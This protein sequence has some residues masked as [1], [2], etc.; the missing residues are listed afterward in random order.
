MVTLMTIVILSISLL[1]YLKLVSNQ[2]ASVARA[3][4][5][6][7][8]IPVAEAG[9]EEALTQ[10]HYNG[11][12][13]LTPNG[14]SYGADKLFHKT[15]LF[16]NDGS[17]YSVSIQPTNPPIIVSTGYVVLSWTATASNYV[18]RKVRVNTFKPR[19]HGGGLN[20]KNS[21]SLSG[22]SYVDSFDSSDP[23]YS[24]GG[25]YDVTKRKDNGKVLTDSGA[26]GAIDVGSAKIYGSAVTGPTGTV[27]VGSG[28]IGDIAWDASHSGAQPG[29][30]ANDANVQF[31]DVDAPFPFATGLP[32]VGGTNAGVY[33]DY[34]LGSGNY[35][36][37][38]VS[39]SSSQHIVVTGDAVLYV[40]GSFSL[41]GQSYIHLAPGASLKLYIAGTGSFAGGGVL[42]DS[43]RA[44]NFGIYGLPSCTSI[45]YNGGSL[46]IG[47]VKA[48]EADF[49]FSGALQAVGAFTANNITVSGN[50][51]VSY[52]EA[53]D[54]TG[55]DYVVTSWN[56]F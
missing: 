29:H 46:F 33:C 23:A 7:E 49:K 8:A 20:A 35:K 13:N 47:T 12:T 24:T 10:I 1:S 53:L 17:Y 42:N 16:T 14:W 11:A 21:V 48:P 34:L 28:A 25:L 55:H 41:A 15:R 30:T 50:A 45:T 36:L 3:Q 51:S 38:S 43:N 4:S 56:E 5:W 6:N 40:N 54:S 39:L 44:A 26:A 19:P 37:D 9:I 32:A 27:T 2:N 22:S 52:D 31:N 18:T